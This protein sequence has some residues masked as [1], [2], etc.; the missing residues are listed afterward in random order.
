MI[1]EIQLFFFIDN[2]DCNMLLYSCVA[3]D[4]MCS[5]NES[6]VDF[7]KKNCW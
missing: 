6:V 3:K 4:N 2:K 5:Y 1:I 7:G